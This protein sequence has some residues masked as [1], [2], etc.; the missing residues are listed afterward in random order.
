[1]GGDLVVLLTWMACGLQLL[2]GGFVDGWLE[3]CLLFGSVARRLVL[4]MFGFWC[5]L[6]GWF[7]ICCSCLCSLTLIRLFSCV[8]V[9]VVIWWCFCVAWLLWVFGC[10]FCSWVAC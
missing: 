3:L 5:V 1:M 8:V 10:L 6:I 9:L 4:R 2:A 7:I